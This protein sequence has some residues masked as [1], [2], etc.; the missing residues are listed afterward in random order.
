MRQLPLLFLLSAFA[1]HAFAQAP[2]CPTGFVFEDRNG[3]G[4]RDPGERGLPGVAVSDGQHIVRSDAQGRWQLQPVD[5]RT[6]FLIKPAGYAV[7]NRRDGLP[8]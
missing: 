4:E 6:V 5:G 8:D 1:S 3:D 2:R 7:A